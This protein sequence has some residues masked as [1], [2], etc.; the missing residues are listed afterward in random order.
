VQDFIRWFLCEMRRRGFV[1][2]VRFCWII[3]FLC[4]LDLRSTVH[5][6]VREGRRG[7][8]LGK[9]FLL[10][11]IQRRRWDLFLLLLQHCDGAWVSACII[12]RCGCTTVRHWGLHPKGGRVTA[13]FSVCLFFPCQMAL[14]WAGHPVGQRYRWSIQKPDLRPRFFSYPRSV[15]CGI[16]CPALSR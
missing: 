10:S 16:C 3:S 9:V 6:G 5:V 8:A 13:F 2:C 15:G 4:L 12:W 1:R 7:F 14:Y 11:M